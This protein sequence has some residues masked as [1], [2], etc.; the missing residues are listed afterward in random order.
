MMIVP[1]AANIPPTP[2]A[3]RDLGEI[4]VSGIWAGAVPRI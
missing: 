1:E 3:D 4:R 2:L